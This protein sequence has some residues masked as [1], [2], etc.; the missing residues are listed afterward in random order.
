MPEKKNRWDVSENQKEGPEVE[1]RKNNNMIFII[2][3]ASE[4][5]KKRGS[6]KHQ[7][8]SSY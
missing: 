3:P 7:N 2:Q 1:K 4:S 5:T 6:A 8:A